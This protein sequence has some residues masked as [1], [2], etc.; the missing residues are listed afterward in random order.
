MAQ[1]ACRWLTFLR[2]RASPHR[3]H[4]AQ[5]PGL[6]M[7]ANFLRAGRR[8]EHRPSVALFAMPTSTIPVLLRTAPG[9]MGDLGR[10]FGLGACSNGA[11]H[12]RTGLVS[13]GTL[14]GTRGAQHRH[15]TGGYLL[16]FYA[17]SGRSSQKNYSESRPLAGVALTAHS[18]QVRQRTPNARPSHMPCV[19]HLLPS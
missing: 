19:C 2:E 9:A 16:R 18:A 7:G 4:I 1:A 12:G 14:R 17:S 3:H 13:T 5:G 15:A 6:A 8:G 10:V 11:T